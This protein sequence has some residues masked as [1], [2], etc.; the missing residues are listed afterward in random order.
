[1]PQLVFL[2]G[3][4]AGASLRVPLSTPVFP[5]S[6]APTCPA[7]R[8]SRCPTYA[9]HGMGARL[10]VAQGLKGDLV[11]IGLHAGASGPKSTKSGWRIT[12]CHEVGRTDCASSCWN[13]TATWGL[14]QYHD[15]K[16]IDAFDVTR[17]TR[18]A[19]AQAAPAARRTIPPIRRN[20]RRRSTTPCPV[21]GM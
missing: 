3:P 4:G 12:A 9:I 11:L 20:T 7:T 17:S 15:L 18:D 16:T 5:D 13:G 14:S 1:M 2:H 19:Q 10:A 6:V 8:G 21:H